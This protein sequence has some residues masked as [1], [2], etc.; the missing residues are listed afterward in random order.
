MVDLKFWL[1]KGS[2]FKF[3]GSFYI[4]VLKGGKGFG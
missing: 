4:R 3:E 1:P 2:G